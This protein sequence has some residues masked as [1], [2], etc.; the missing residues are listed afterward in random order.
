MGGWMRRRDFTLGVGS[1]AIVWP[2]LARAQ[3]ASETRHIGALMNLAADDP[4]A[5]IDVAGF[6]DGLQELGWKPGGNLQIAYRWGAGDANLY[7]KYAAEL[8]AL[9][10][11]V[12]LAIG[13]TAV[14]ALQEVTRTIPVVFVKVTDPVSRGLVASLAK[15]GS[16]T[17]GFLQYEFGTAG[18]WL[19]LLKQIM[20]NVKRAGVIRDVSET[21]GIGQ[22]AAIQAVAP[23]FG[24]DVS[25]IDGRNRGEIE[26]A[27]TALAH[28]SNGGLIVTES[29][30]IIGHRKLIIALAAEHR[31][32]AVYPYRYFVTD[33]GLISYG[34]D[35]VDS[36]RHAA[37]YVDRILKGETPSDLP[38]QA[39]TKYELVINLKTARAL[40]LTIPSSLLAGADKLIE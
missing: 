28:D 18:K 20:P 40:Q 13:G 33:G 3:Q 30:R 17:T 1:A 24:I 12:M 14:S 37:G 6:V 19:E 4:L 21:S 34:P 25:P 7:R 5:R 2:L 16:N 26:R 27:I 29:G 10:P 32:P 15:P 9:V 35:E 38:V 31:L 11:D 36:F 22:M 39:P 8:A 23:S